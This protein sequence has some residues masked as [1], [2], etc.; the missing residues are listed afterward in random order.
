MATLDALPDMQCWRG[1]HAPLAFLGGFGLC[2]YVVVIPAVMFAGLRSASM[3]GDWTP[4]ELEAHAWLILKYKP[5][6]WWF[7]FPLIYNKILLVA[8]TVMLDSHRWPLLGTLV[9]WT[10]A[11]LV[12]VWVD[13]PFRDSSG[14]E[15]ATNADKLM[16]LTLVS[17]LLNYGV[18]AICMLSADRLIESCKEKIAE[19][20]DGVP[21]ASDETSVFAT[22]MGL[23]FVLLPVVATLTVYHQEQAQKR[24][25]EVE[26]ALESETGRKIQLDNEGDEVDNPLHGNDDIDVDIEEV[27]ARGG[28]GQQGSDVEGTEV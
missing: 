20:L 9:V 18:A 23:I 10:V 15:G 21:Q 25:N 14:L 11:L 19:A 5:N 16:M 4:H 13:K 6:R 12:L 8:C 3:D 24:E 2:L 7:E 27:D 28:E 26:G 17:Q 22:I 1:D